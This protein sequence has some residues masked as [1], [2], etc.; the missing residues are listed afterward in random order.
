MRIFPFANVTV[1]DLMAREINFGANFL[2]SNKFMGIF[3]F[4]DKFY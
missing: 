4:L 2:A 3:L 1:W